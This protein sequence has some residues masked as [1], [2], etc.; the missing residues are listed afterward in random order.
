M[1]FIYDIDPQ[2]NVGNIRL[3]QSSGNRELDRKAQQALS[4]AK[5]EP[6]DNG[7]Q[8]LRIRVT[9]ERKGTDFQAQN[10][11]RRKREEQKRREIE[12]LEAERERQAQEAERAEIERQ[13]QDAKQAELDRQLQESPKPDSTATSSP[14]VPI[15]P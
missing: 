12:R 8:N 11:S 14:P 3:S 10:Q 4:N 15:L 7:F 5:F 6:T 9:S 13:Q 2:G 1:R